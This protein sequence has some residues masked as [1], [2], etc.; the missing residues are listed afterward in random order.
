[1]PIIIFRN[2]RYGFPEL[3]GSLTALLEKYTIKTALILETAGIHNIGDAGAGFSQK[4]FG[5]VDP[6]CIYITAEGAADL[7]GEKLGNK[8]FADETG[9]GCGAHGDGLG[10][11][12]IAV[13]YQPFQGGVF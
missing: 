6:Q 2:G 12:L 3:P 13:Y 8:A 1:M 5:V 9:V 7:L 11:V 4:P 10:I